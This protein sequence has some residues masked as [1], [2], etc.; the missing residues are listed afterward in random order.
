MERYTDTISGEELYV[1]KHIN[2]E[3]Y[4]KDKAMNILHRHDGPAI[5]YTN[6]TKS[7]YVDGKRHRL[8]G[9]A[10]IWSNGDKEWYVD[11]VFIMELDKRGKINSR[12]GD[13]KI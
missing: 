5:E 11:G 2:H 4:F 7:W 8:D 9:P 10:I 1:N 3:S 12:M 13:E 6:G